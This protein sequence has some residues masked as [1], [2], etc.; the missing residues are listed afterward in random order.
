MAV[1]EEA[2]RTI[3]HSTSRHLQCTLRQRMDRSLVHP[4]HLDRRLPVVVEACRMI[5]HSTSRHLQHILHQ[6]M[7]RS[8]V[9]PEH[10]DRRLPAVGV[11]SWGT[12]RRYL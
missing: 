10:L 12:S 4:E 6:R 11:V 7:G 9:H 1:E 8:L 2:C 3:R 5:R